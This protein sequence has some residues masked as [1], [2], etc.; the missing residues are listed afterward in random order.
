MFSKCTSLIELKVNSFDTAN[1][2][3]MISMFG[4]CEKLT[5]LDLSNFNTSQVID[6]QSMFQGCSSLVQLNVSNFDTTNV[7]NMQSMFAIC[8]LLTELDVISFDTSKVT[9]MRWMFLECSS[10]TELDLSNFNTT[11]VT[12]MHGMVEKCTSLE[13]LILGKNF[14]KVNGTVMFS[15]TPNLQKV[16]ALRPATSA[17]D[18][19]TPSGDNGLGGLATRVLYVPNA[20]TESLYEAN[21]TYASV[22]GA[23]RIE[24][25]MEM[26]GKNPIT[27]GINKQYTD[28]GVNVLGADESKSGDYTSLGFNVTTSGMPIDTSS[29]GESTVTY[30][31]TYTNKSGDTTLVDTQTRTVKVAEVVKLM[32]RDNVV[33][34]LGAYRENQKAYKA[35]QVSKVIFADKAPSGATASWDVSENSTG[36]IMS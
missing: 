14:N 18:I 3:E 24:P 12:D 17:A 2:T 13:T 20:T 8:P 26:N 35:E 16:I 33:L 27:V 21:S 25:I 34:M 23:D 29:I 9:T 5:S 15:N 22:L 11:K 7:E 30:K 36:E 32:G 19:M 31:L 4:S 1:V 10:L 6:M 28:A